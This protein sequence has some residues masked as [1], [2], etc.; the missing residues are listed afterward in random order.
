MLAFSSAYNR[1]NA[2]PAFARM[3]RALGGT[4]TDV[5][6]PAELFER[7]R[8]SGA[9]YALRSLAGFSPEVI[10]SLAAKIVEGGALYKNPRPIELSAVTA[11]L[12]DAYLGRR[13]MRGSSRSGHV[14]AKVCTWVVAHSV[15]THTS[16]ALE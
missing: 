3:A 14:V 5:D 4:V 2:P 9:T 1:D 13:P 11:M 10:P 6:V 8:A 16:C 12:T 7:V 15:D